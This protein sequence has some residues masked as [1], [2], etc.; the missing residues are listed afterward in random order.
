MLYSNNERSALC[1]FAAC[2]APGPGHGLDRADLAG[3]VVGVVITLTDVSCRQ[4][5][6]LA[7]DRI[8]A[9]FGPGMTAIAGP[10]G[11][12]KTTLLR[13]MAGL[14]KLSGG[15]IG[16]QTGSREIALLPQA[17]GVDRRFPV[18]CRELVAFGAWRRM[19]AFGGLSRDD[20]ARIGA[21]MAQM[22]LS[23]L[24]G[25]LVSALSAG[26]FQR[27]LFARLIV[28]DAPVILLDEPT[29]AVDTATE[30]DLLALLHRW[31]DEGRTVVAV[32][33]DN[34][35]ILQHFPKTLLMARE[36]I[37][38]GA[39]AEVLSAANRLKARQTLEAD[40]GLRAA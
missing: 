35:M 21:A 14:H 27:V 20:D 24:Q 26:Q 33:H 2:H 19:G 29:T 17:G 32:L 4:G 28:Q 25:R 5:R 23:A 9:S 8:S 11:A 15:A 38:F 40:T 39:S 7:V 16:G 6:L 13:A 18:T 3:R 12:G 36:M 22:G 37:A 31:G 30:A 1:H 34:D 10:N